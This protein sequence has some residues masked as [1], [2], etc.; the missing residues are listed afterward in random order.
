MK[1]GVYKIPMDRPDDL[2]GLRVL[3]ETGKVRAAEIMAVIAKTEG[4]GNVNDFT[5]GFT[6]LAIQNYL[7]ELLSCR[8]DQVGERVSIVCSGGCE[9]VMSPHATI[10]TKSSEEGQ[11][12]GRKRLAIGVRNT[13]NLLPEEIGT[14]IHAREVA[15]AVNEAIS[16]AGIVD[17]S[18]VHFVQIKCPLLT[19]DRI[20]DAERRGKK[21]VTKDTLKSMAFSRGAS[22][23][24]IAMALNEVEEAKVTDSVICNDWTLYS[25]VASTS[26]GIELMNNEI[27]VMGNSTSSSSDFVIGHSA[28]QDPIDVDAVRSALKNVGVDADPCV[29]KKDL[30][31]LV[32]VFAKAG[33]HPNGLVRGRRTTM[34]TDSDISSTRHAR[35]TVSAVIAC[36]VGDPMVYVSGGSEHQGPLGGGPVAAIART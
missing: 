13:R 4:N 25:N 18:D 20:N 27:V 32:N 14:S 19:S 2:D 26:A 21:V 22:A 3:I 8:R 30:S 33:A 11:R 9:G 12:D 24:G 35:A 17:P 23:L 7:A 36:I 1:I 10:F 29:S 5:R 34:L 16:D 6:T 15:K 28:M 31:R